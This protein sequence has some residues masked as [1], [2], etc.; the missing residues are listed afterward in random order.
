[1]SVALVTVSCSNEVAAGRSLRLLI[2]RVHRWVILL[3]ISGGSVG[4]G[5]TGESLGS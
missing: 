3:A 1:M 2:S 4:W 5:M